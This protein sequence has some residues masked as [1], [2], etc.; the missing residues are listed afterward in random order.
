MAGPQPGL[1][2]L[3]AAV[4]AEAIP[5]NGVRFCVFLWLQISIVRPTFW[6]SQS[7]VMLIMKD[8]K[9][10]CFSMICECSFCCVY[11]PFMLY[12]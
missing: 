6:G 4:N 9:L 2:I 10:F 3:Q 12:M 11:R 7:R 8:V 1:L 5:R